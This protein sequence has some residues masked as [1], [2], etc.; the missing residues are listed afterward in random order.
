MEIG[1]KARK[2]FEENLVFY[3]ENKKLFNGAKVGKKIEANSPCSRAVFKM[4][5]DQ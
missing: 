5:Y 3:F 4:V 1:E 2:K